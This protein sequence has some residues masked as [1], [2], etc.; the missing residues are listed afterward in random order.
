MTPALSIITT[1]M[2]EVKR[3]EKE[4]EE[5]L[6]QRQLRSFP[7]RKRKKCLF[8]SLEVLKKLNEQILS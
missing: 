7:I 2:E 4:E 6:F 3:S 8:V 5:E 1:R